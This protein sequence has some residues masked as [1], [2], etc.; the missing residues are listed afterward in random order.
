M[1]QGTS[2]EITPVYSYADK[3]KRVKAFIASKYQISNYTSA[4]RILDSRLVDP[5][6]PLPFSMTRPPYNL[7]ET[8]SYFNWLI[9]TCAGTQKVS[10]SVLKQ[11]TEQLFTF[12]I[13]MRNDIHT[14]KDPFASP[15]I[16]GRLD[17][18]WDQLSELFKQLESRDKKITDIIEKLH[19][20]LK[21]YG[22]TL[23]Q[24]RKDYERN[25]G[26]IGERPT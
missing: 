21:T 20:L 25:A 8:I 9:A 19:L 14:D 5:V 10:E 11:A 23:E 12:L 2:E 15:S 4:S 17:F 24:A 18:I 7:T 22:P 26:K 3:V 1:D 6:L 16:E 13:F